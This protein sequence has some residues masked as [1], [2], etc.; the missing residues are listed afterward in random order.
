MRALRNFGMGKRSLENKIN[1]EGLCLVRCFEQQD[2]KPF[3]PQPF[4]QNAVANIICSI[5]FGHRY[6]YDDPDFR[7]LLNYLNVSCYKCCCLL[8]YFGVFHFCICL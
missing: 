8:R 7:S 4:V 3:D 5:S 2:E 6:D 1:E